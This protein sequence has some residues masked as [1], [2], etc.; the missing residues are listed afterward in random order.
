MIKKLPMETIVFS[1][2]HAQIVKATDEKFKSMAVYKEEAG[3]VNGAMA[4]VDK[5]LLGLK[6]IIAGLVTTASR[7]AATATK[8]LNETLNDKSTVPALLENVQNF[9][10]EVDHDIEL[11]RKIN[12]INDIVYSVGV[13]AKLLDA[14]ARMIM[15]SASQQELERATSEAQAVYSRIIKN[16]NLAGARIREIKSSGFVDDAIKEISGVVG[17]V[18]ASLRTISAS[19][20]Q[21]LDSMSFVDSS[22]LKVKQVAL[23]QARKSEQQVKSTAEE[24]AQFVSQVGARVEYFKRLLLA[25]TAVIIALALAISITTMVCINRS[26]KRMTETFSAIVETGDFTKSAVIKNNDEFGVTIRA[27]NG[28]VDSFTGIIKAV[29]LSSSKLSNSSRGLTSTAQKIHTTIGSQSANI[30]QVSAAAVEM[31]QTVALIS[32]NTSKIASAAD[33]A[34]MV[35]VKGAE[36]VGMTGNEVQQIAQVVSET[37]SVMHELRERSQQIGDIVDVIREI[38]D[39]TNLLA[40]NAAIEAA[41]AGDHGRGFAVVADEVRKLA[42]STAEATVEITERINSIQEDTERAVNTMSKSLDR[43]HRGVDFSRQAGDSLQQIVGSI[44]HL[45][46]MTKEISLAAVDMAKA[47]DEISTDIVEIERS[48]GETVEAAARVALESE[49]LAN[50]SVELADEISRYTCDHVETP[51]IC[52]SVDTSARTQPSYRLTGNS[53]MKLL[54]V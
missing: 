40:L 51:G 1:E 9:R 6:E 12:A 44:V 39:Q 38:T 42:T 48:S 26:L 24:Q 20:K 17:S 52:I 32:E 16:V 11:N 47:A 43:V 5:S 34:R 46:D 7:R 31:S 50:L 4:R 23:E 14:K 19:Q 22:V 37:T 2:L 13:D 27:F 18:A 25:V 41:R 8:T 29:S 10:N 15:L 28:L 45:Q 30:G 54:P 21:V 35:A 53:N 49:Q 33:D 3:K 36:V